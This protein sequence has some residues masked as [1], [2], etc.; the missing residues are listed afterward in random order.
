MDGAIVRT[1]LSLISPGVLFVFSIAFVCAWLLERRHRYLLL[2][3]SACALFALGATSQILRWPPDAG[4]NA[5]ISG[6]LYTAAVIAAAEGILLRSGKPLGLGTDAVILIASMLLLAYFFYVD[7]N[8]LARIYIQNFGYGLILLTA[9]VRLW[10]LARGRNVDRVLFWVLLV[11][12]LHFFPR[13]ILTIGFSAPVGTETF[14]NSVFWQ[15]L[16]LSLAVLGAALAVAILAAAIVDVMDDLRRERDIDPLTGVLNRRGFEERIAADLR[17]GGFGA[18]ALILCDVDN[19]KRI[20]DA[21]GHVL[22]DAVLKEVGRVLCKSVRKG[23]IVG[24]L[25]GEEFAVFLPDTR[26]GEAV[27]CAERLRIAIEKIGIAQPGGTAR[28]PASFGVGTLRPTDVW[29][30]LYNRV[31]ARLYQAKRTGRN[32]TIA[33]DTPSL[34]SAGIGR[35]S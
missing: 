1:T 13:T 4:L 35:L 11:F 19:F 30:S 16:Q 2:L 14:A 26:P 28:I 23:D 22:G 8:L 5:M 15:A 3:A 27:E 9:A 25:G 17:K 18:G 24:R 10:P 7:R 31:D 29:S 32:R 12:A 33:D 21:Y 20:N 6:A 34:A